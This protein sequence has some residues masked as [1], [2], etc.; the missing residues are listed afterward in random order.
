MKLRIG[1]L[2]A[3]ALG[4]WTKQDILFLLSILLTVLAMLQEYLKDRAN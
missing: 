2:V 1:A 4:A 3:I